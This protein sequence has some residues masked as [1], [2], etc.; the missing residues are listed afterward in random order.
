METYRGRKSGLARHGHASV[1][2][3]MSVHLL[4]RSASRQL[5]KCLRHRLTV[6][7][8]LPDGQKALRLSLTALWRCGIPMALPANRLSAVRSMDSRSSAYRAHRSFSRLMQLPQEA[9]RD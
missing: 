8:T 6:F 3:D 4:A 9:D 5:F 2:H 7:G 1:G